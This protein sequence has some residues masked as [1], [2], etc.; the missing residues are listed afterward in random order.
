MKLHINVKQGWKNTWRVQQT[1]KLLLGFYHIHFFVRPIDVSYLGC[2]YCISNR[3]EALKMRLLSILEDGENTNWFNIFIFIIMW[4]ETIF[5]IINGSKFKTQKAER[6]VYIAE[7][8]TYFH[9]QSE[10]G[11]QCE[12][13][14]LTLLIMIYTIV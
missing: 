9:F 6:N 3:L 11:R 13:P 7:K 10:R 5:V 14:Y 4:N 2:D 12:Q 1:P 8:K